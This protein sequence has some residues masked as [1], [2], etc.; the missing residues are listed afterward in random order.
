M[1]QNQI[2]FDAQG[3][4]VCDALLEVGEKSWIRPGEI[5]DSFRIAL[6]GIQPRLIVVVL[7]AF[8]KDAHPNFVKR[9]RTQR[10]QRLPLKLL[11]LVHP[12]ITSCPKREVRRT[13]RIR[14]MIL[15]PHHN[16]TM[17]TR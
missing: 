10:V 12:R 7:I 14:K 16:R 5:A 9:S 2:R 11:A 15:I 1:K 17:S 4:K 6:E 3:A 13:V 8:G